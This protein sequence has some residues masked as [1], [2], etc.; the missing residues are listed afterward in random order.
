MNKK[1]FKL[2]KTLRLIKEVDKKEDNKIYLGEKSYS[3]ECFNKII[4]VYCMNNEKS[5]RAVF[6]LRKDYKIT[7]NDFG[8]NGKCNRSIILF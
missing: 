6:N 2:L 7:N 1:L 8:I 4:T 3:L 5:I